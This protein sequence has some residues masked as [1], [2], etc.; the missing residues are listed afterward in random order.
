[1]LWENENYV[2][3]N[4]RPENITGLYYWLYGWT[5]SYVYNYNYNCIFLP[6]FPIYVDVWIMLFFGVLTYRLD[7]TMAPSQSKWI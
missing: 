1:M 4:L 3:E 2:G 6:S 7:T 5:G